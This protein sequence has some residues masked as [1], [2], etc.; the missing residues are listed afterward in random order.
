MRVRLVWLLLVGLLATGRPTLAQGGLPATPPPLLTIPIGLPP[1]KGAPN[2]V[3]ECA[4][5]YGPPTAV[6]GLA[7]SPDGR[8]L[9]SGGYQEVLVWDL[10]DGQLARRIPTAPALET[11]GAIAFLG[12]ST[13]LVVGGGSA[14]QRGAVLVI[15][16][17]TGQV[18]ASWDQPKDV[19]AAVAVSPDAK[20]IAGAGA[21]SQ[22]YVWSLADLKQAP[23]VLSGHAGWVTGVCFSADGKLLLT[24]GSDRSARLWDTAEWKPATRFDF[25][26][27]LQGAAFSADGTQ[28]AVSLCGAYRHEVRFRVIETGQLIASFDT[29]AGA[30]LATI[31]EPKGGRVLVPCSDRTMRVFEAAKG[32][33]NPRPPLIGHADWVTSAAASADGSRFASGSAD[34]TVKVWNGTDYKLLATLV[35]L[36]PRQDWWLV[37]SSLGYVATSAPASIGWTATGFQATPDQLR[38]ALLNPEAVRQ[39]LAGQPVPPPLTAAPT[40]PKR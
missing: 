1:A 4:V 14:A 26:E 13:T 3:V 22:V 30:P 35:Q 17:A 15:D 6:C 21:D 29:G 28:I 9:A 38:G 23:V 7:F 19:I 40:A 31:W 11:I 8:L 27:G 37:V 33:P 10:V 34:G 12:G 39:Q 18:T 20:L 5:A 24:A 32:R 16:V 25:L 2:R 36:V